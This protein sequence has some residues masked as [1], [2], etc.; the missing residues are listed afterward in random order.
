MS[1]VRGGG[2]DLSGMWQI[3]AELLLP[4]IVGHLLRPWIGAWATRNKKLLGITD[5]SSILLV[6]YTAFSAAVS[7]GIWQQLPPLVLCILLLTVATMLAIALLLTAAGARSFGLEHAD[8]VALVFCGSQKSLVAGIPIA[9]ALFAGPMLGMLVLP[10]MLYH[11][12]Q[13]VAGAWL[14]RRYAKRQVAAVAGER[15]L[16]PQPSAVRQGL[17]A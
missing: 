1:H 5:R 8:E 14:A 3:C 16:A 10:V 17:V 13:L 15:T 2:I 12:M 6:V 11:P 9:N 4:F 7:H